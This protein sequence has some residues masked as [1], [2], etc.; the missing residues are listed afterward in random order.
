MSTLPPRDL[1]E[2]VRRQGQPKL[3]PVTSRVDATLLNGWG[4]VGEG[5]EVAHHRKDSAGV[6]HVGGSVSGG[7]SG[8]VIFELPEGCR[9]SANRT[10]L[11]TTDTSVGF[12]DVFPNGE[13][14]HGLGGTAFVSLDG[15]SFV[16]E[17]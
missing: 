4:D 12:V 5:W 2:R 3:K 7:G 11:V 16:A 17:Q 10:F 9:P 6:V 15:V 13:I 8:T 14:T 1:V